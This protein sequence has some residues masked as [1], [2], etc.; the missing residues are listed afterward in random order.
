MALDGEEVI[1]EYNGGLKQTVK[2]NTMFW[3]NGDVNFMNRLTIGEEKICV[4]VPLIVSKIE[5]VRAI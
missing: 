5:G 1:L 4:T 3:E 2:N